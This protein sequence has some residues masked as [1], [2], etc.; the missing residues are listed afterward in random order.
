MKSC[1]RCREAWSK[2]CGITMSEASLCFAIHRQQMRR[3]PAR[4]SADGQIRERMRLAT[5]GHRARSACGS[6]ELCGRDGRA[7]CRC[8]EMADARDLKSR[9]CKKSCGFESR[10]RHQPLAA[11]KQAEKRERPDNRSGLFTQA[12][13]RTGALTRDEI[14]PDPVPHQSPVLGTRTNSHAWAARRA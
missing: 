6:R 4:V 13:L 9:D 12:H 2:R 5:P 8:G 10:H 3:F 1:K 7:N 14:T 11:M